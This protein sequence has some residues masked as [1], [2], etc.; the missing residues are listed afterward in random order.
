M[1]SLENAT[2][3]RQNFADSQFNNL[4][5]APLGP[6]LYLDLLLSAETLHFIYGR[7]GLL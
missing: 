2:L 3:L 4:N 1:P 7:V 5:N 6:F